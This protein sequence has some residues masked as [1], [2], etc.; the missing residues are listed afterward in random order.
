MSQPKARLERCVLSV[1]LKNWKSFFYVPHVSRET[2]PHGRLRQVSTLENLRHG[3][4]LACVHRAV[5][6]R[7]KLREHERSIWVVC[8]VLL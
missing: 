7:Q 8:R 3:A 5:D 4:Y 1:G 2:V 6:E